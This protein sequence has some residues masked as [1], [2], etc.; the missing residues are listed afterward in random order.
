MTKWIFN[1]NVS[2]N[3]QLIFIISFFWCFSPL[4][5]ISGGGGVGL[6]TAVSI[7][8]SIQRSF[9][10]FGRQIVIAHNAELVKYENNSTI[11]SDHCNL[12]TW[13]RPRTKT[14]YYTRC[15]ISIFRLFFIPPNNVSIWV[16]LLMARQTIHDCLD[17]FY[18]FD[19]ISHYHTN[20]LN[21][22]T[23]TTKFIKA[24]LN[25][26]SHNAYTCL[27]RTNTQKSNGNKFHLG[28]C[29]ESALIGL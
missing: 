10:D 5:P 28:I 25:T 18:S 29:V 9:C 13:T 3:F 19:V 26:R 6:L 1:E 14:I 11:S 23:I 22:L 12:F 2:L 7:N 27:Q 21:L 15:I 20:K 16:Y 17:N 24:T 8:R 4:Y